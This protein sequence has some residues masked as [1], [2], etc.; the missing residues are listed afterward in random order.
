MQDVGGEGRHR[1]VLT[2]EGF[3]EGERL[4][5][6]EIGNARPVPSLER[7]KRCFQAR[8]KTKAATPRASDAPSARMRRMRWRSCRERPPVA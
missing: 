6:D 3:A 2:P 4:F 8:R 5:A 7:R 1:L